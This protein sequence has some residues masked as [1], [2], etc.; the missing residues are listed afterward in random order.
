MNKVKIIQKHW[1]NALFIRRTRE[2]IMESISQKM[3]RVEEMNQKL[4][5]DWDILKTSK[6]I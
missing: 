6:R 3:K 4:M 1:R 5:R 2:R